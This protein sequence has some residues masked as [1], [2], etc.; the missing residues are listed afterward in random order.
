MFNR[1][2]WVIVALALTLLILTGARSS[3]RSHRTGPR[4]GRLLRRR[5]TNPNLPSSAAGSTSSVS[6]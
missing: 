2:P 3:S 6:T 1:P 5:R 4:P